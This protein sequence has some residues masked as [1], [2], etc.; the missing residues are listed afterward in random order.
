MINNSIN[1]FPEILFSDDYLVAIN[2]PS[3][4]SVHRGW[5]RSP[6]VLVDIVKKMFSL[7]KVFP[8]Q[9]LDR[10]TSGVI[11][12]A[13]DAKTAGFLNAQFS[14]DNVVKSYLA[15]VRGQAPEKGIIDYPI[16]RKRNGPKRPAKTIFRNLFTAKTSPRHVSVVEAIPKT[17][18]LH[19]VR[20][21]LK[22]INCPLIGDS[23]YGKGS[24][25]R[26]FQ[27]NY[28]LTRLGLHSRYVRFLHPVTSD[29]IEIF[30]KLPEDLSK[31]FTN[32][33]IPETFWQEKRFLVPDSLEE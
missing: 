12:F 10:P 30:A 33:G 14:K 28:G 32:M 16:P 9:R 21:H 22:H 7:E 4:I 8:V 24:L 2:K 13:L 1:D 31:P 3:G 17:G 18:R 6:V 5:D 20:R 26:E 25:N 15:L 11:V 23:K 29:K 19:Q 27:D